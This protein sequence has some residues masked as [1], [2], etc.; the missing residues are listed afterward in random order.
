[1]HTHSAYSAQDALPSVDA[2]VAKA[3][4]LGQRAIGLTDHGNMAGSVELYKAAMK[5]GLKPFPGSELYLVPSTE[6][7][8]RDYASKT[9]KAQR[10]H[11]GVV[12]YSTVGYENLVH[13]STLSHKNH[14]HKPLVDFNMLATLADEGRLQGLAVT[15][16]CYFGYAV[17]AL[18][19]EGESAATRYLTTLESWFP[20][21]TYVEIQNH[22]IDHGDGWNDDLVADAMVGIADRMGLPVVITQ[23]SHYV[24]PHDKEDHEAL[25]RLVAFGPDP[26]DAV[27]PGDGFHMASE[28]WIRDH[29]PGPR[30]ERGLAGLDHLYERGD[31]RIGVL[32]SYHYSVPLTVADPESLLAERCGRE[33]VERGL[34]KP[35]YTERL[36]EELNVVS[37]ARMA[38]YLLLVAEV[39]DYC[40]DEG[41]VFQVRGSAGGSLINWLLGITSEDPLKWGMTFERF[42]SK[43]R[44]KPPDIDLDIAHD[45]RQDLIEWLSSR[46]AVNQIGTWMEMSIAG[47][48]EDSKGSLLV[49]YYSAHRKRTGES[50]KW[51]DVPEDDRRQLYRIADHRPFSGIGTNAAGLV[52]TSTRREFERLVPTM[53]MADKDAP[54]K[55]RLVSQYDLDS[56]E[57]LG[58]VKFDA[59]GLKTLTVLSRAIEL[60]KVDL[61]KIPLNDGRTFHF[62]RTGQTAGVFQLEGRS[63]ARGLRDLKPHTIKD[64]IAAMALFRPAAMKSGATDTFINRKHKREHAPERHEIITRHTK[65]THGVLLYQDQVIAVLRDLGLNND[66]LTA[67]L[68]AIKASNGNIGNAAGV[69]AGLME[70]V[71]TLCDAAG[72]TAADKDWLHEAFEAYAGYGFNIAHATIYGITAY[73][74]A[75]LVV[76]Y[77]L[78]FHTALLAVAAEAKSKSSR[79]EDKETE[80]LKACVKRGLR[81]LPP[82]INISGA[83]Y[84]LDVRRGAIRRGLRSVKGVGEV[85]ALTLERHQPY[86]SLV[87][88]CERTKI[89][90]SK[91][92]LELKD[93]T[94]LNGALEKLFEA[95]VLDSII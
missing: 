42:L 93:T 21:A 34:T 75:Y 39:T 13:L 18:V 80:Y 67:F 9:T 86:S 43:D 95:G 85:T 16:G 61:E 32:D 45:R 24:E 74:C 46:Y 11:L 72:M 47:D 30:L 65:A 70:Q 4:S 5:H 17:Q 38:G 89:S 92:Y 64:V 6:Q 10:Y 51:E 1:M 87:D 59:L 79:G 60:A 50:I 28:E 35:K 20:G 62:M 27:F 90:G 8:R 94:Q 81:I 57:A 23:D 55:Y 66:D 19:H 7:Y 56:V 54:N 83:S 44:T 37:A 53:Y 88:L 12:A 2:I 68:K 3:A 29:H 76:H 52:V 26:D 73:R 77:P 36:A 63:T 15:T 78:E 91:G 49:K 48:E 22:H 82:D 69:I 14:F 41:I 31:L 71:N 40:R 58:L 33:L 84:T 25:K